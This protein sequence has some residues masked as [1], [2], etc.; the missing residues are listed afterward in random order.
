MKAEKF[1]NLVNKA[2]NNSEAVMEILKI[3]R[4]CSGKGR[5]VFTLAIPN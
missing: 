5:I 4:C 2:K 1:A 3:I